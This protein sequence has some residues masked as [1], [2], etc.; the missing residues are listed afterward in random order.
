MVFVV[1]CIAWL[2]VVLACWWQRRNHYW[3]VDN[4]LSGNKSQQII[5][6]PLRRI[7]HAKLRHEIKIFNRLC[8]VMPTVNHVA[9][10]YREQMRALLRNP[11]HRPSADPYERLFY[12]YACY[13]LAHKVDDEVTQKQLRRNLTFLFAPKRKI[14]QR[15]KA[16]WSHQQYQLYPLP[17][18][19]V[20]RDTYFDP[21]Q[22]GIVGAKPWQI[23]AHQSY[24]KYYYDDV[25]VKRYAHAYTLHADKF[26]T[27]TLKIAN[28]KN[29]FDCVVSRG[30]VTC[31]NLNTGECHTY[32]VR[33]DKVRLATSVCAK[34]DA[35]EMYVTWQGEASISLD[36]GEPKWLSAAEISANQRWERLA[37][38]AYQAKFIMGERLRSRYLATAKIIPSLA[39]L[40]KV[41]IVD[42]AE[43]FLA[44]WQNLAD[45]RQLARLFGG[46][47]LV[48]LYSSAVP[49]IEATVTT[50]V[51]AEMV[52]ACHQDQLWLYFV[53]RTV[54][55][56]DALYYLVKLTQVPHYEPVA[57]PPVG[58]EFS[59]AWPYVKTLT[60]TNTLP[61]KMT[62]NLIIPLQFQRPS[63]VSANGAVLTV[64][65]LHTG[66]VSHYVLPTSIKLTGEW[67]T[68]H[69]NIP[70]KVKLAGYESR[71]FV[72]TRRENQ[73]KQRLT[74][75]D[76]VLAL[77]EIQ[78]KTD[79]KK[80]DTMF[81]KPVV[82]GE[83][84][85]LLHAVKVAYQ[86][87]SRK[88]LM[89]TL[90]DYHQITADVWQYLLTQFVGIRVRAE[91]IYLTPC[92]NVM[93]EF[94]IS[95]ECRGEKYTFNTKKNLSNDA[96]LNKM[97]YY[98]NSNG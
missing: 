20:F 45:Y 78:I 29:D 98:G 12:G 1:C 52:T 82:E 16:V 79:D 13:V 49:D 38:E 89:A 24:V 97:N 9:V 25:V 57:Q 69:I 8:L 93:G 48:L 40:T 53:D 56:P 67:I 65:S 61:Q 75:K 59:K 36:G 11:Q 47:N 54:L 62:Q 22:P 2:V 18:Y 50:T 37:T 95:F 10:A 4:R 42:S 41:V 32:A 7:K 74:K 15:I 31:K 68:T 6:L 85:K 33:G 91:K 26:Q 83:D 60:V 66:H 76:L 19:K 81:N 17:I 39:S 84:I 71:Q 28:N 90:S 88:L 94:S 27:V 46:F 30:V 96:K 73:T 21:L 34:L 63:V 3:L 72:I 23:T 43:K 51:S 55:D 44:V 35:L 87:Q 80:F 14:V 92:V 77:R 64:V 5:R 58:L 86:N 70:L